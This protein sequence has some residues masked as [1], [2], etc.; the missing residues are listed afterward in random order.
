M[1]ITHHISSAIQTGGAAIA[2][3]EIAGDVDA[4]L[5][6]WSVAPVAVGRVGLRE[7][8]GVDTLIIGRIGPAQAMLFPHAGP[9]VLKRLLAALEAA[10]STPRRDT[11]DGLDDH[12]ASASE[13]ASHLDA[14]LA[15][16]ASPLAIDLLLEQPQRWRNSDGQPDQ[17]GRLSADECRVL[18][19]LIDPPLV[20]ALG[21]P[22]VGKSSLLNALAGRAVSVVADEPGTTRDHVGVLVDFAGLVVR[23]IDAPGIGGAAATSDRSNA[24]IQD[25][26]QRI[27]LGVASAAD[28]IL[29]CGDAASGFLSGVLPGQSSISVWLRTDLGGSSG[30]VDAAVSVRRGEGTAALVRVVR[31]RLVP[32]GLLADQ[33]AW[34]Y[35]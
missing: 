2:I 28:L 4:L 14:A 20:V 31:D 19:R 15:R 1:A 30:P 6:G 16:A 7:V 18:N 24:A 34:K 10:G 26:A 13:A 33:R 29:F 32:P 11:P 17:V 35:W 27:A 5:A 8:R 25:E 3:V 21:P 9:A 22:N 23:F 12:P